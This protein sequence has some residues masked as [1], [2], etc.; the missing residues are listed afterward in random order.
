MVDLLATGCIDWRQPLQ[1]VCDAHTG[2][3]DANAHAYSYFHADRD[4]DRNS[5]AHANWDCYA[6]PN[7]DAETN[8]DALPDP[9]ANSDT[10]SLSHKGDQNSLDSGYR[11]RLARKDD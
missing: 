11:R 7:S 3:G 9:E 8:S 6:L 1:F 4:T 2:R 10:L 5:Y